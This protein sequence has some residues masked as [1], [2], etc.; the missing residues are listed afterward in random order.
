MNREENAELTLE[1]RI[2]LQ[3]NLVDLFRLFKKCSIPFIF[4]AFTMFVLLGNDQV[5]DVFCGIE[6]NAYNNFKL[7]FYCLA[8]ALETWFIF[9]I[10]LQFTDFSKA[11]NPVLIDRVMN[12]YPFIGGLLVL[13]SS[14]ISSFA[15]CTNRVTPV[16]FL[17]VGVLYM[18]CFLFRGRLKKLIIKV[19]KKQ[20]KQKSVVHMM[21]SYIPNPVSF[22]ELTFFEKSLFFLPVIIFTTEVIFSLTGTTMLSVRDSPLSVI[23][24]GF[25]CWF[26]LLG[27]VVYFEKTY[28]FPIAFVLGLWIWFC[29]FLNNNHGLQSMPLKDEDGRRTIQFQFAKWRQ[30]HNNTKKVI[31]VAAEGGGIRAA[32]WTGGILARL[33]DSIP[34]FNNHLFAVSTVSGSSL[35]VAAYNVALKQK[36]EN[37][38]TG[39]IGPEVRDFLSKDYLHHLLRGFFFTDLL[40]RILPFAIEGLDRAKFLETAWED[41]WKE[42]ALAADSLKK[43]GNHYFHESFLELYNNQNLQVHIPNLFLN[44]TCVETGKPVVTSNLKINEMDWD[45]RDVYSASPTE[46]RLSDA[47]LLSARFPY[48]TPAA[49]VDYSLHVA[50]GGYFDNSGITTT[51]NLISELRKDSANKD[52]KFLILCIS[53]SIHVA[54]QRKSAY[55]MLT[56]VDA[57]MNAWDAR[58][59]VNFNV[60]KKYTEQEDDVLVHIKLERKQGFDY[61]LGWYLSRKASNR[62]GSAVSGYF[63]KHRSSEVKDIEDFIE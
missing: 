11:N 37:K 55:E 35:G 29:S 14:I 44:G 16:L 52:I 8:L 15:F 47:V 59:S 54:Q 58:T 9:F 57:F 2:T 60:M 53:N 20:K 32:Y 12:Y 25:Y 4:M 63:A 41:G 34:E 3:T 26:G 18:C 5:K 36:L 49:R 17:I 21:L 22:K 45:E 39:G 30:A 13:L 56:P 19:S 40:Q 6:S 33:N 61:P 27:V 62:L 7:P 10:T 24:Q 31:L 1:K 48:V 28:N 51:F 50:D 23:Y 43:T 46:I 42:S 38:Y